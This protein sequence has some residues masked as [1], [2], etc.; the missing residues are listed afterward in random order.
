MKFNLTEKIPDIF[1]P[2][3]QLNSASTPNTDFIVTKI[4]CSWN[5]TISLTDVIISDVRSLEN[6]SSHQIQSAIK[7]LSHAWHG[8][9]VEP[10][11]IESIAKYFSVNSMKKQQP[12]SKAKAKGSK[13]YV[14]PKSK[15]KAY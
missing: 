2:S 11:Y 3:D 5:K 15:R 6:T 12:V 9:E 10:P 7:T 4:N 13:K 8:K 1:P 14:S